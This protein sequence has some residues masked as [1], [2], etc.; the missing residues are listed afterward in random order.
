MGNCGSGCVT[1]VCD[2]RSDC[3]VVVHMYK[4]IG[5]EGAPK[6]LTES[7]RALLKDSY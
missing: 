1:L 7:K 6:E 5:E 2:T 4:E 3:E